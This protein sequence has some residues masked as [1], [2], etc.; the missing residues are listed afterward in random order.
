MNDAV[1][2]H[3][4]DVGISV[5]S[6]GGGSVYLFATDHDGDGLAAGLGRELGWL[7]AEP[8]N[9]GGCGMQVA[10][11]KVTGWMWGEN[12][13]WI[14]LHCQNNYGPACAGS[15]GGNWGVSN[16]KAGNLK[17]YAWGENVGWINFSCQ[18]NGTCG[19]TANYG[20]HINAVTGDFSGY[21]WGERKGR[22]EMN[23]A[24]PFRAL[25]SV[26]RIRFTRLIVALAIVVLAIGLPVHRAPAQSS[27]DPPFTAVCTSTTA[28]GSN[29]MANCDS[30][31]LAH[32]ETAIAVDPDDPNHLVGGSN[33]VE[34]PPSGGTDFAAKFLAGYYTSFDGGA[35][36]LN[37]HLPPVGFQ[38]SDPTVAF[39]RRGMSTTECCPLTCSAVAVSH[40]V[41]TS[42]CHAPTTVAGPLALG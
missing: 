21:A 9:C 28:F 10:D 13:G 29:V 40:L 15:P 16:D 20:V 11:T 30:T 37:G 2:L 42:R 39:E 1:A 41:E 36:W 22:P 6:P 26:A 38:T 5:G 8:A 18:N 35:T 3:D 32:I 31:E 25:F 24:V 17:G 34:V 19:S 23:N 4:A 12:T 33:D 14:N 7:N 27:A